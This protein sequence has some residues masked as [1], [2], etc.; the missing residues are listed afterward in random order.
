[1]R[2][3]FCLIVMQILLAVWCTVLSS[4]GWAAEPAGSVTHTSG[5]LAARKGDGSIRSLSIN[6][7]IEEGDVI[8]TEKRTY[9]R[10]KFRDNSEML[11][12]PATEFKVERFGFNRDKPSDD[13][14]VYSL[15]KGGLRA[16][17]GQIGKRGDPNSYKMKTA[18]ATIGIRGTDFIVH[19]IQDEPA[20]ATLPAEQDSVNLPAGQPSV[21]LPVEQP[22]SAK[23]DSANLPV[24]QPSVNL[25]ADPAA[26]MKNS[27]TTLTWSSQ[28]ATSCDIS[29]GIG[30]VQPQGSLLV[31]PN[32]I[33]TYTITCVGGGGA[34]K[35]VAKAVASIKI[36]LLEPPE[37]MVI[38]PKASAPSESFCIKPAVLQIYFDTNKLDFEVNDELKAVGDFLNRFP[39]SKVQISGHTDNVASREYNQRLSEGRA[40]S[41]KN[42]IVN[43]FGI[44]PDR[45]TTRG[46]NFSKPIATNSTKEGQARNRRIEANFTCE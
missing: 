36:T 45:I 29:P 34:S 22:L 32:D 19:Y 42:Y 31:T 21:N 3:L 37:Q 2:R 35:A 30:T 46:Y 12:K 24:E 1:M 10:I 5:P 44:S 33:T 15:I 28:N 27:Q 17:T 4:S 14:A 11:L 39:S 18:T 13:A 40:I 6:S 9:A 25:S 8:M 16:V 43:S 26:I 23:S 7:V 38:Q 41:V 20:S